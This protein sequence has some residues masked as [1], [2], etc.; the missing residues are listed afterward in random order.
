MSSTESAYAALG[1][2]RS[3]AAPVCMRPLISEPSSDDRARGE[4]TSS[5]A[6]S[7]GYKAANLG[8]ARAHQRNGDRR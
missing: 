7:A 8:A 1:I 2:L 5:R 4:G 3:L 6:G